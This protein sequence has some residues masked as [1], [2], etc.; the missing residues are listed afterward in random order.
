MVLTS[1]RTRADVKN[2]LTAALVTCALVS[3]IGFAQIPS[4]VRVSAPFEGETGEPNTFGGYLVLMLSIITGFY[5]TSPSLRER[6]AWI[7]FGGLLLIPLL[8][9]LSRSSWIAAIGMIV[10]FLIYAPRK[11]QIAVAGALAIL[12]FPILA[13]EPVVE[14]IDYTFNQPE[15]RGQIQVGKFRLDTS[16]S[17]RVESWR[18]G[19]EGWMRRPFIGYG[20]ANFYFMDAQY[21]RT[22]TEAGILGLAAFCWLAWAILRMAHR[23]LRSASDRFSRA[24]ALGYLA[25]TVAMLV[26]G[27]G[28]N[29]FIIVRIMEPF[30]LLT[31]LVVALPETAEAEDVPTV[32]LSTFE[33]KESLA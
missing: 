10:V 12:L 28:A 9:T 31:A 5:L 20:V 29:T 7:A 15:S 14:R 33:Q 16:S 23:R 6:L 11:R 27:V 17:A 19:L 25:G 13:P 26:H 8:Y 2:Y 3:L 32:S 1:V 22:L 24:L 30:W 21:I 4:G 18:I